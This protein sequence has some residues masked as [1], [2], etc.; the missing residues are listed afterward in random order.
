VSIIIGVINAKLNGFVILEIK[1]L[2]Y[3][4]RF[5]KETRKNVTTKLICDT[6]LIMFSFSTALYMMTWVL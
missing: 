5:E 6:V 3:M 2:N 4:T 1:Q